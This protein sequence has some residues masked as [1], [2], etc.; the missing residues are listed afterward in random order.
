[1]GLLFLLLED[2]GQS[3]SSSTF[4]T[5]SQEK[6]GRRKKEERKKKEERRKNEEG[7]KKK[8]EGLLF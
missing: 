7:R 8:E 4:P 1:M 5:H 2:M 3:F 6:K